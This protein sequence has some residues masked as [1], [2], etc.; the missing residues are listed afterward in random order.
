MVCSNVSSVHS[1]TRCNNHT[2]TFIVLQ[3]RTYACTC[4]RRA[5]VPQVQAGYTLAV[6]AVG[7]RLEG[8]LAVQRALGHVMGASPGANLYLTP[9]GE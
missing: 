4:A 2:N 9:P 3:V 5:S 6:R 7:S 8:V 1:Y